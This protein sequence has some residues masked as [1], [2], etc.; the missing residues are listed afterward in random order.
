[1]K[2]YTRLNGLIAAPFTAFNQ[3]RSINLNAIEQ[4]AQFLVEQGVSGAFVCGTTG[5][6]TSLTTAE[7][8]LISERWRAVAPSRLRVIVHVGHVGLEDARELAR[9]AEKVKA[10]AI[11]CLAPFFFKPG[12]AED[13]VQFCSEV[14]AAAPNTPFFYYQIPSMTGVNIAVADFL[15]AAEGRI[16]TLVGVKFTFENLM[17][18]LEC[19]HLHGGKYDMVF[20][21][22]EA[23]LAGLATG[24]KAAIGS[25]YNFAAPIY[26]R[27]MAAFA[28]NDFE[29]A[30][31]EQLRSVQLI[32]VLAKTNFMAA[33]KATMKMVGV[34]VGPSRLPNKTFSPEQ[35]SALRREL[36]QIGFFDWVKK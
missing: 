30:R 20:G 31:V 34:D 12:N 10:D 13:L 24:A 6:G 25:T 2:S 33:A 35:V 11:S 9:H 19:S 8:M 27:L 22:D 16:P 26:H 17:D 18:F 32:R 21:R 4:Q 15:N 29:T 36:E 3:D 23:M 5:E 28:K 14:A 1:M 7:R